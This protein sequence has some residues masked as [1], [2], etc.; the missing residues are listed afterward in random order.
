ML[1]S[2]GPGP[3]PRPLPHT[4][5]ACVLPVPGCP[6]LSHCWDARCTTF[7][8]RWRLEGKGEVSGERPG[9]GGA[10]VEGSLRAACSGAGVGQGGRVPSI[11]WARTRRM[12]ARISLRSSYSAAPRSC[13]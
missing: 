10:G 1:A 4:A 9:G 6:L 2:L 5:P 11:S 7:Q 12:A 3:G 13:G 8:L